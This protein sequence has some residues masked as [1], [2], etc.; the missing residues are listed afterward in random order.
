MIRRMVLFGA[1]GD[2][3]RRLLLPAVAQLVAA[4][5][6]P[7]GLSIVGS[8]DTDWT[9]ET[10]REHVA[11]ALRA[12]STASAEA[13]DQLLQMLT[14]RPA[15]VT[16]AADVAAV[17]GEGHAATLVYLALPPAL[18]HDV[19][20]ALAAA[21]LGAADAVA[22]EKPF[23][24]DLASARELN[25]LLRLRLPAPTVFRVDHFLS[26][27]LVRRVVTLRFLNRVF[28]PAWHAEHVE[29]IDISWLEDLTLEGRASYYDRAGALKDML[30][31]H[32]MEVMALVLMEQPA[33]MD[34]HSFRAMRV[35]A[36]R[37][38]ATPDPARV[39]ASTVRARYTA[40]TIGSR[41]VPSYVD[42]PGVDPALRTET[43][44]ALT[45]E[46]DSPRWS[47][48][49]VTI[50][51]G[52]ALAASS[53]E[54]AVHFRP[55]PRYLTEQWPGVEPNVLRLGL[56]EPYVHLSTTLNGPDRTAEPRRL[57][58]VSSPPPLSP[59]ANLV[60]E[61]LQG[62]PMLFIRGDEAEEAWR[63]VDPVVR[64]WS[65]QAVPLQEYR[66]GGTPPGPV[67]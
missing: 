18:L 59:Y 53:A 9:T 67:A 25:E 31:N 36:L 19:L 27:E 48:V 40:G 5:A 4:G 46:V 38:V 47:G 37:A 6:L 32:L 8:A 24:T 44:A 55:V 49:P 63:I 12:H 11:S 41:A 62:D 66:A 29:R 28:S 26:S 50:R 33:R 15:D 51:S 30:Q 1:S 65:A 16:R 42:E 7:P 57:E 23:G 10:F 58:T 17:L 45:L 61:M 39:R 3:A 54:I 52:K 64:A 43:Y 56:T 2:L 13:H 60:R 20:P 14:F 22:I 34:A 21:G 35:E